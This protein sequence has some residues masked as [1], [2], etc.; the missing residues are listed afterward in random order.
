MPSADPAA[1]AWLSTS[2][3][4]VSGCVTVVPDADPDVVARA[5]GHDPSDLDGE[6]EETTFSE[7]AQ[8][9]RLSLDGDEIWVAAPGGATVVFEANGFEGTRAEVLR[10][11][12]NIAP[13]KIAAS[14]FWNVN[15]MA[16]VTCARRGKVVASID[17][18]LDEDDLPDVPRALRKLAGL[19]LDEEADL[20]AIGAAMVETFVGTGFGEAD[21]KGSRRLPIV[22]RP[23]DLRSYD[24]HP[25]GD[26]PL[27]LHLPGVQDA[28]HA[29]PRE[30]QRALAEWAA[31]AAVREAG[32]SGDPPVRAMLDQ[33]GTG[34]P[35]AL[36]PGLEALKRSADA[37]GDR[38][39]RLIDG[40]DDETGVGAIA[41]F[42]ALMPAHAIEALRYVSH[43]DPFSAA[44]GALSSAAFTFSCARLERGARFVKD[45]AGRH[46]SGLE[47]SSRL[48]V[49][50]AAVREVM[51]ADQS[52][53]ADLDRL[54]PEPLTA[55]EL[56]AAADRDRRLQDAGAFDTWQVAGGWS[57][58]GTRQAGEDDSAVSD[59]VM[60]RYREL[61][62]RDRRVA[63]RGP[64]AA[65]VLLPANAGGFGVAMSDGVRIERLPHGLAADRVFLTFVITD[66]FGPDP[67]AHHGRRSDPTA[68]IE[69]SGPN[70]PIM[71]GGG[72]GISDGTVRTWH[73]SLEI[74]GLPWLKLSYLEDG[75]T[76]ASETIALN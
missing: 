12:A 76:V 37:E 48:P 46:L 28:V 52:R 25:R 49:F 7:T 69:Y 31:L 40:H 19:C 26:R 61:E 2:D 11:A 43:P 57:R 71:L 16:Q 68:R 42:H 41:P 18:Y 14:L 36:S 58:E 30:G 51:G 64:I 63:A 75:R 62:E 29:M 72:A 21:I 45:G 38:Q 5:F 8:T 13:G 9:G 44:V 10:H 4:E 47:P 34:A 6:R 22:S 60:A 24:D 54:L 50:E 33:F 32:I 17:L 20:L 56:A 27:D 66:E 15:G 74:E 39:R 53:W 23:A 65:G 59:E 70:G 35:S 73:V 67:A 55:T 3:L 1:Y